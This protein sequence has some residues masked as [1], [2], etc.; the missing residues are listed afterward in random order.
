MVSRFEDQ[1]IYAL[2]LCVL[3]FSTNALAQDASPEEEEASSE[4]AETKKKDWPKYEFSA[5]VMTGFEVEHE[6]PKGAQGGSE[7]TQ[8][9]FF[10][11]QARFKVKIYFNKNIRTNLSADLSDA[12]DLLDVGYDQSVDKIPF[13]R[14]AYLNLKAHNAFQ[15][16]AGRFKLPFSRLEN[17]STGI[18]P[19]RGRGL[20]NELLIEDARWGDR[21][22]GAMLWGRIKAADLTWRVSASNLNWGAMVVREKTDLLPEQ[23]YEQNGALNAQARL[24]YDPADWISIGAN[25]GHIWTKYKGEDLP[26]LPDANLN[27]FGGDV[28]LRFGDFYL[29]SEAIAGQRRVMEAPY[30]SETGEQITPHRDPFAL[31]VTAYLN[32]DISLPRDLVLQPVVFCEYVDSDLD[33]LKTEA[34]RVIGGLNLLVGEHLRIMPQVEIVRPLEVS[35]GTW[36][37]LLDRPLNEW[38]SKE[39]YYLLVAVQL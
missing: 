15:I 26:S 36:D 3:A 19:F 23:A 12:L 35:E 9:G 30:E 27:G 6:K 32:Y 39:T 33:Y 21:A 31:G 5:R 34:I 37:S 4:D 1:R 25:G 11:R 20:S 29:A 18:L 28:R 10:L 14:N 24:A 8:F 16:R 13:L 7:K 38:K 2:F 22:I 17:R